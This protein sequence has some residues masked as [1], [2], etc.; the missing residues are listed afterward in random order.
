MGFWGLPGHARPAH[1]T[2]P[3]HLSVPQ[4]QTETRK[5]RIRHQLKQLYQFLEEQE[6]FFMASL[7]ELS[8]TIGQVRES[9]STRVSRDIALLDELIGE[10]EAKQCQPEW[11]LMQVSAAG[12]ASP[13]PLCP[14]GGHGLPALH[15]SQ[16]RTRVFCSDPFDQ[17][18]GARGVPAFKGYLGT[19]EKRQAGLARGSAASST[20]L[21]L[22][23]AS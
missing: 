19:S 2:D 21:P 23:G 1:C 17:L 12:P 11:E 6:K 9:Y 14:V 8:Q 5:Q 4:K 3:L 13:C 22:G 15:L 10:L 20:G 18:A 16:Y 7:E